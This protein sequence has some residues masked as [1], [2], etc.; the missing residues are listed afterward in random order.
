MMLAERGQRAMAALR[1]VRWRSTLLAAALLSIALAVGAIVMLLLYRNQLEANLDQT[2]QQQVQDRALLLDQGNAPDALVT[3]LQ[4]EALV[5][6]GTP[7][8]E[9]VAIG[10]AIFPLEN[11]VPET[12]GEVTTLDLLVEERKP[13]EVERERME[14]RVGSVRTA[15][16][17]LVV[18]AGAETEV[19]DETL[20]GLMRLFVVAV[21]LLGLLVGGVTFFIA[22]RVLEPVERIR[23]QA[24]GIG[25]QTLGERVPVPD[26]GDEIHDLAVTMNSMLDRL[27]AHERS[28]R[29]FSADAS[30]ELK[31]PIANVRA[32]V[33]TTEL[34]DPD[35]VRLRSRLAGETDRLR[36]LVDNLL[37][38]ATTE[39]GGRRKA[40]QPVDLDD[41][42]FDEAELLASTSAVAVDL[43]AVEPV[44]AL[45]D[46][47]DLQRLVRNLS[48]NAARHAS[49]RVRFSTATV[50]EHVELR[51][52]D[53][54]DG[55]AE[56]DRTRVFERFTR[57]DEA[58]ARDD[59]GSG[60]G[61][62]IVR[63]IA[64]DH[65]GSID[66]GDAELGGAEFRVRLPAA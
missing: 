10:G 8:G 17:A 47:A 15:D 20:S 32:L 5:W 36:D 55:V 51:V 21:P 41:L 16:G 23:A 24:D 58:R 13:D 26:S 11:P 48:D 45:G 52:A 25:G 2:L 6:I 22:G 57:L 66:I 1:T 39:A 12:I 60:L 42:V 7:S 35:W 56:A 9:A 38:L 63:Q 62:S 18:L 46:R 61:L 29:Q 37:F 53:D 14:L 19:I 31:S 27:E 28:L 40:P 64:E 54:G 49:G 59:G 34:N 3:V 44:R 33:D 4:E 50:G 43:S 30:H 65:G